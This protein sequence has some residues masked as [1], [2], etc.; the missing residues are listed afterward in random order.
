[1]HACMR[2][3]LLHQSIINVYASLRRSF[4]TCTHISDD[5]ALNYTL[6][7]FRMNKVVIGNAPILQT[8]AKKKRRDYAHLGNHDHFQCLVETR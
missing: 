3:F 7:H 8:F 6:Y 2:C 1:M 5:V 4:Q